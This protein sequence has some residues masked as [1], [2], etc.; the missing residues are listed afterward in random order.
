MNRQTLL[1]WTGASLLGLGWGLAL[2]TPG[3]AIPN[4]PKKAKVIK[5]DMVSA[6]NQ[7]T[8]PTITHKPSLALPACT[9]IQTTTNNPT[10]VLEFGPKGSLSFAITAVKG[11]VKLNGKGTDIL[12]NGLPFT[13]TVSVSAI[14]RTT[15][16][17]CSAPSYTTPCTIV[18]FPFPVSLVCSAGKCKTKTTAN[19]EVPGAVTA[20]DQGSIEIN[21]IVVYDPDFDVAFRMGVLVP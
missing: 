5:V 20:G 14:I 18:D 21:Q 16:N 3:W 7:C 12:N 17:G 11:D 10:N 4:A 13:G 8:A 9:P 15:D 6:Y 2:A 1:T 19:G